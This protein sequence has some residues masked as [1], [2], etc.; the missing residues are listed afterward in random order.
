MTDAPSM[1]SISGRMRS[2][3]AVGLTPLTICMYSGR[4]V[5]APNMAK[6]MTKPMALAA[7]KTRSRNSFSGITGSAARRSAKRNATAS[8]TPRTAVRMLG[9][10]TQAHEIPPRLAKMMSDVAEPASSNDPA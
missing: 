2:P 8:T 3:D 7:L 4:K 9:A 10:E 1:P 6:P 5:S